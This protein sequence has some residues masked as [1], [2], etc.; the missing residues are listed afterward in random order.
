M[1]LILREL[2]ADDEAAFLE[3]FKAWQGESS[4]WHSFDWKPGDDF[5]A[6]LRRLKQDKYGVDL[7]A[8]RVAHSMLYGV[9][10]GAIVGR[11]SIRHDLNEYL[12]RRGGHVGYGVAPAFRRRGYASEMFRQALD[13]CRGIGLHRVMITCDDTNVGSWKILENAGAELAEK[14][15]DDETKSLARRYWLDVP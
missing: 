1:A 14:F 3:G 13:Y 2:T 11:V 6:H 7:P 5:R 10:D 9:V 15:H 4:H 8:G 12:R